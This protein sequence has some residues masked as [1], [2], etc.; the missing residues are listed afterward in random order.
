MSTIVALNKLTET[1]IAYY[2]ENQYHTLK[3]LHPESEFLFGEDLPKRIICNKDIA[4]L[5]CKKKI[6]G[7]AFRMSTKK[8]LN[9]SWSKS[10]TLQQQPQQ[11]HNFNT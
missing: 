1:N 6:V 5:K 11:K 3:N 8:E 9:Y 2:I 10:E 7:I 4:P